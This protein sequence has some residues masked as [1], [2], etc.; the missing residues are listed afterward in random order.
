MYDII[1]IYEKLKYS[2]TLFVL[3]LY[4]SLIM[5]RMGHKPDDYP[6]QDNTRSGHVLPSCAEWARPGRENDFTVIPLIVI[7]H[8]DANN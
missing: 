5:L 2:M 4:T 7:V 8:L 3:L 1:I 6:C